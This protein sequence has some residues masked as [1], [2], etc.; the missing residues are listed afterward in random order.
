MKTYF[1]IFVFLIYANIASAQAYQVIKSNE[2]RI[3]GY[4]SSNSYLE[5]R[6]VDFD[7]DSIFWLAPH[8]LE[9]TDFSNCIYPDTTSSLGTQVRIAENGITTFYTMADETITLHTQANTGDVPWLA[10]TAPDSSWYMEAFVSERVWENVLGTPDSVKTFKFA[11]YNA[12]GTTMNQWI[13]DQSIRIGKQMG[14]IK[15]PPISAFPEIAYALGAPWFDELIG[16]EGQVGIQDLKWFE[17]NDFQVDDEIHVENS[18]GGASIEHVLKK[19]LSR[20]DFPDSIVY[21]VEVSRW[22][23]Q[24]SFPEINMQYQGTE[25]ETQTI[26]SHSDFDKLPGVP[27]VMADSSLGEPMGTYY[28]LGTYEDFP[29]KY[30]PGGSPGLSPSWDESLNCFSGIIDWPWCYYG[31]DAYYVK[32]LGGPYRTCDQ[33]MSVS[34]SKL[35]YFNKSGE[36]W[37]SPLSTTA[38]ERLSANALKVYPN[39][40]NESFRLGLEQGSYPLQLEVYEIGGRLL[41]HHTVN[42]PDDAVPVDDL[43]AGMLLL[44][45]RERNGSVKFGKIVVQ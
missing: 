33:I 9:S 10:Y 15:A 7:G 38:A 3:Y 29:A 44:Q 41:K 36:E 2:Q 40:A 19:Y 8:W 30:M 43:P 22:S 27:I 24:G 31:G 14:L 28:Q 17:V 32:G 20:Q 26:H 34:Y 25:I 45:A 23:N 1:P 16:I 18:F 6:E 5:V 37:G 12:D 11:A 39:P 35:M 13:T 21:E 4:Y 42:G